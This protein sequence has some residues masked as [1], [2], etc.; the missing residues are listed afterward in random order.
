MNVQ[1]SF[2]P[3]V[4]SRGV[5]LREPRREDAAE[6][7]ALLHQAFSTVQTRHGF[8]PDFNSSNDAARFA[9]SMIDDP[10]CYAVV[11]VRK[12][13]IVGVNFLSEGDPI[14]GVGPIAVV[15]HADGTGIG[16]RLM[17][18]VIE[19]AGGAPGVRLLQDTFNLKSLA[20]YTTLGF[21]AREPYVV[22]RGRL[23]DARRPDR[24][25]RPMVPGDLPSVVELTRSMTGFPRGSDVRRA[26]S[27][28]S[29]YVVLHEN[30]LTGYATDLGSWAGGHAVATTAEDFRALV[31]GVNALDPRPLHILFPTR[32][33]PL[34]RWLFSQGMRAE[35]QM[36]LMTRGAYHEPEGIYVPS[37][38]Y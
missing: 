30:R 32:Q 17:H 37:V 7:G 33:S 8:Q 3:A 12:Q 1:T 20:L 4:R 29:P 24:I 31:L 16:R 11:A 19:R 28:G 10:L 34:L 13:S 14:R 2:R 23:A 36:L 9:L 18:N 26:L 5:A 21:R 22:L 6:I 27:V 25:V 15:P 38:L 35:K